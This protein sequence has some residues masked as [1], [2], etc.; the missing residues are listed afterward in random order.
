MLAG[1]NTFEGESVSDTLAAVLRADIEWGLLPADTSPAVRRLLERCLERDPKRRLRDVGDAWLLLETPAAPAAPPRRQSKAWLPWAAAAVIAA[2]G[3]GWGLLR[4]P[5]ASPR[6]VTRWTYTQKDYFGFPTLSRDGTRLLYL[7]LHGSNPSLAL[8]ALNQ[9]EGK[10]I[11]GTE[12]RFCPLC[13]PTA[14]G[15][16]PA[17][18][19]ARR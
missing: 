4:P 16:W 14:S 1:R 5:A 7:E 13:L 8:R 10:P 3:V 18:V 2:A 11:P 9:T 6:A 12:A 19:T 15:W 17:A